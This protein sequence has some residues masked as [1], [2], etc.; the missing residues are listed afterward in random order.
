[1]EVSAEV[2]R[3]DISNSTKPFLGLHSF[4]SGTLLRAIGEIKLRFVRD[5]GI[6]ECHFRAYCHRLSP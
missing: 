6:W 1:M 4:D 3:D 2:S 5:G